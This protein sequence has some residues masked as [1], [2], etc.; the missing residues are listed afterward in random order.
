V[1]SSE[2]KTKLILNGPKENGPQLNFSLFTVLSVVIFQIFSSE[3]IKE[4]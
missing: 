2:P 1:I 4:F 3:I